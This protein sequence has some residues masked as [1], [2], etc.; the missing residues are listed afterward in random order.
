[1]L[2]RQEKGTSLRQEKGTS[3]IYGF[4][5]AEAAKREAQAEPVGYRTHKLGMRGPHAS[6][7]TWARPAGFIL[8]NP[9]EVP[10]PATNRYVIVM[11]S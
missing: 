9:A 11:A 10:C 1:V 5:S 2:L 3:L 4:Q 7:I 6:Y 8:R